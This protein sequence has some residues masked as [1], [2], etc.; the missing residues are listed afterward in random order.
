MQNS[1]YFSLSLACF[2]TIFKVVEQFFFA[3][4]NICVDFS[5]VSQ[6]AHPGF[7]RENRHH[8]VVLLCDSWGRV[9]MNLLE[10]NFMDYILVLVPLLFGCCELGH[11]FDL[12]FTVF[13][14][15]VLHI[16]LEKSVEGLYLLRD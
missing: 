10:F 8:S 3:E 14:Y 7:M 12:N 1:F 5:A 4:L 15:D 13:S 11:F 16:E 9:Y 2:C 6:V